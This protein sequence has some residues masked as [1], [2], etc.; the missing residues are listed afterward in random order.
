MG[1]TL[2]RAL[3]LVASLVMVVIG[4]PVPNAPHDVA[5]LDATAPPVPGETSGKS[6]TAPK[7]NTPV[8]H[9]VAIARGNKAIFASVAKQFPGLKA[10]AKGTFMK[11]A[12]AESKKEAQSAFAAIK[13]I[14]QRKAVYPHTD[15]GEAK[16]TNSETPFKL[17]A[18]APKVA[19]AKEITASLM[20][21]LVN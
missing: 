13:D 10:P 9:V 11:E 20:Q 1:K 18:N 17:L 14:S 6:T 2:M 7:P 21:D 19:T 5:A 3:L 8:P 12:D 15:L 4:A 16:Q